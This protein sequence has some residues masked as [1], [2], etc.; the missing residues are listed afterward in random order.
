MVVIGVAVMHMREIAAELVVGHGVS[1][2]FV[3]GIGHGR[4][5]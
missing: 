1:V 2:R 4:A 3:V 5:L